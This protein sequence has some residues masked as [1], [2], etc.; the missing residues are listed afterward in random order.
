[1][2]F[3]SQRARRDVKV[4]LI[5]QGPD[6]LFGGYNRHL[7]VYYGNWWRWLPT[8]LRSMVGFTIN[9]LSRNETL[10]RGVSSLGNREP[11]KA[12]SGYLLVGAGADDTRTV[13]KRSAS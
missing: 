4:V 13:S 6:E 11:A 3:V 1:M 8:G 5:G 7:G 9:G 10:K 12:V 2:Y